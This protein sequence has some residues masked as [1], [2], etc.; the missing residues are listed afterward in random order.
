MAIRLEGKKAIVADVNETASNALC[1]NKG[2]PS[3]KA[4]TGSSSEDSSGKS[5]GEPSSSSA[6]V[7]LCPVG[8]ST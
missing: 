8:R 5:K 3:I 2:K 4:A 7:R 1:F 6:E